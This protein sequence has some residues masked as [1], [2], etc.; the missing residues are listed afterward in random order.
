LELTRLKERR[1]GR[2][3][4]RDNGLCTYKGI[5]KKKDATHLHIFSRQGKEKMPHTSG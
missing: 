3:Q 5:A 1:K 2:L 4:G